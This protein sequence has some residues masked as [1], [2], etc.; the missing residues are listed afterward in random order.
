VLGLAA[1][2]ACALTFCRA[3]DGFASPRVRLGWC[4]ALT[5][6]VL[7]LNVALPSGS[8]VDALFVLVAAALSMTLATPLV[9]VWIVTQSLAL[10]LVVT[11]ELGWVTAAHAALLALVV[12]AV[13][14]LLV[15][16]AFSQMQARR[17]LVSLNAQLRFTR[18]LLEHAT[19]EAERTRI[20]RDLHDVLGHRLAVLS[21]ELEAAQ[22]LREDEARAAAR[23]SKT[24]TS[25]LLCE[26]RETVGA[27]T[28]DASGWQDLERAVSTDIPGLRVHLSLAPDLPAPRP[29]E[30]QALLRLLQ[31]VTT[32]TVRH[33]H[34]SRLWLDVR[35]DGG[36]LVVWARDDG[37]ARLPL[38]FGQGLRGMRERWEELGGTL[39][40]GPGPDGALHVRA[41]LHADI[42]ACEVAA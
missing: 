27:L 17:E 26:V 38:V 1:F 40:V 24:I 28:R 3:T 15:Q 7:A 9:L 21:V 35:R 29:A 31:E 34:A 41:R 33:A 16:F 13:A 18:A 30:M 12:Q 23:R 10:W 2:A 4:A 19:R 37:R 39:E 6:V 11:G 22:H 8:D 5:T 25:A 32:N 36:D 42:R 20:T 14:A